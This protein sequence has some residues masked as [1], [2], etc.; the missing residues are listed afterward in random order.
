MMMNMMWVVMDLMYETFI[1]EE[2]CED[3]KDEEEK[4]KQRKREMKVRLFS[5]TVPP[6]HHDGEKS[7]Q[8]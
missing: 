5:V 6:L 4:K 8:L 3:Y 1:V 7:I 2:G